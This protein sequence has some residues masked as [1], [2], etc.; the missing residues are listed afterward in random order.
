MKL[1]FSGTEEKINMIEFEGKEIE[2]GLFLKAL[3]IGFKEIKD[4]V[5][6]IKNIKPLF[7]EE[8]KIDS[9]LF[10][11]GDKKLEEFFK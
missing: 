2:E 4:L 7:V 1:I 6:F 10:E 3:E 11:E 5:K 9:S 8:V